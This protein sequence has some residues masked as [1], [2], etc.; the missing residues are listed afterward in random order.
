MA[1]YDLKVA[2]AKARAKNAEK[3]AAKRLAK[4]KGAD[5]SDLLR[6][7]KIEEPTLKR[8]ITTNATYE[9]LAV[10]IAAEPQRPPR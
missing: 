9:A 2:S 3:D 8:Y 10:L 5:I 7:E 4:N 6:P 1:E